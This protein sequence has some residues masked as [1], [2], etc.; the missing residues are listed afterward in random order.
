VGAGIDAV[1]GGVGRGRWG[2]FALSQHNLSGQFAPARFEL[3][4]VNALKSLPQPKPQSNGECGEDWV[5]SE[6]KI[7]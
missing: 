2:S 3:F 5:R 1:V 7:T 6:G 4:L